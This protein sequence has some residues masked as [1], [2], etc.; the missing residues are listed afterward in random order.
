MMPKIFYTSNH[1]A[2]DIYSSC[3]LLQM[4]FNKDDLT[5]ILKNFASSH[6]GVLYPN[7]RFNTATQ[8]NE[9]PWKLVRAALW[10]FYANL[11]MLCE[12]EET[13]LVHQARIG[14][15][16]FRGTC[17]LL[18]TMG[19]LPEPPQT[20]PMQIMLEQLRA[21]REIHVT[22]FEILPR[23]PCNS[24]EW[25]SL[26]TAL[27]TDA[28]VRLNALRTLLQDAQIGS[29]LWQYV[30]WLIQ[31]RDDSHLTPSHKQEQ[32]LPAPWI[33][34]QVTKIHLEFQRAFAHRK[35]AA[36][37]HRARIW[38]KRLRYTLE[39]FEGLLPRSVQSWSKA[40][41]KVQ[42]KFGDQRDTH[43][44]ARLA[45]RHGAKKIAKQIRSLT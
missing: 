37:Q 36:S 13:E 8:I 31:L 2:H 17:R 1:D 33:K 45:E 22:R 11:C 12:S 42:E 26:S 7:S 10:Q 27:E 28:H 15:R 5:D 30:L 35:D 32:V 21:L 43:M 29:I 38:A 24:K 3:L 19:E 4:T 44:A 34:Q 16:R 9:I 14:W 23:I 41:T 6:K 40:V 20:G 25:Q 39:D 18:R